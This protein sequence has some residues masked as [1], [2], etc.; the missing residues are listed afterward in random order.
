MSHGRNIRTMIRQDR[1]RRIIDESPVD[2][3]L[4]ADDNAVIEWPWRMLSSDKTH[5]L[6]VDACDVFIVDSTITD[7]EVE[8]REVIEKALKVDA[9]VVVL[10]DVYGEMVQTVERIRDGLDLVDDMGYDGDVLIPLQ[11]P[12]DECYRRLEGHGDWYGIGGV[13]DSPAHKKVEAAQSVR[14]VAGYDIRLHGFGW[15]GTNR[16]IRAIRRNPRLM[17]TTDSSGPY[18]NGL[19]QTLPLTWPSAKQES[20]I[21]E[22]VGSVTL[23]QLVENMRR[24]NPD[25]TDDPEAF[26]SDPA[27]EVSW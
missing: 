14:D 11:P 1:I 10:S 25:L 26:E 22:V 6:L 16:T 9:E 15:G 12:H 17:D 27:S 5:P 7:T 20:G 24:M 2:L 4:S 21:T 3:Y 18:Q 23:A 13:K 8:N 19:S